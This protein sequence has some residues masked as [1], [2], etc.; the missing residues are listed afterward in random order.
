[1]SPGDR[2]ERGRSFP[3]PVSGLAPVLTRCSRCE[4]TI[5]MHVHPAG[6]CCARAEGIEPSLPVLET[7]GVTIRYTRSNE[8][9]PLPGLPGAASDLCLLGLPRSLPDGR[10]IAAQGARRLQERPHV[11]MPFVALGG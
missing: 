5:A 7:G 11:S 2:R 9:P 1:S 6:W 8:K 10:P 4:L 3:L